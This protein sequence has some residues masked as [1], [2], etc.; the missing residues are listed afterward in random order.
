VNF[1]RIR[2]RALHIVTDDLPAAKDPLKAVD[3]LRIIGGEEDGGVRNDFFR[4][5]RD[6]DKSLTASYSVLQ[7]VCRASPRAMARCNT[8]IGSVRRDLQPSHPRL[9]ATVAFQHTRNPPHIRRH[10]SRGCDSHL[11]VS[12]TPFQNDLAT[13]AG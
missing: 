1:R 5:Y 2:R 10:Q 9:I 11:A 6:I 13:E 12:L 7:Q 4:Q 8:P 3:R